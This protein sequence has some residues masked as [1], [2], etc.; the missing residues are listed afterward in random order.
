MNGMVAH[1]LNSL[2]AGGAEAFVV[3]LTTSM[4]KNGLAAVELWTYRRS[5]GVVG[6]Q[7]EEKLRQ[8][9]VTLRCMGS[10]G[11]L[12]SCLAPLYFLYLWWRY[13][14]LVVHTHLD[15]TELLFAI[16]SPLGPPRSLLMRTLHNTVVT[17]R[18]LK[19]VANCLNGCWQ[20]TVVISRDVLVR[21]LPSGSAS[22]NISLIECG[23]DLSRVRLAASLSDQRR[24]KVR[25]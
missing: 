21:R 5:Q 23:I 10:T 13:R 17:S 22:K 14:P 20:R 4:H 16:L 15:T 9:G 12:H 19:I 25:N 11:R 3:D 18:Y 2:A 7:L 1:V 6:I 8:S 24:E